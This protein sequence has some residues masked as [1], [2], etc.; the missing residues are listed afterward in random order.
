MPL[1]P[2]RRR[3]ITGSVAG[4][5]APT[6]SRVWGQEIGAPM[7]A[8][9]A[10]MA[11]AP[12]RALPAMAADKAKNH[13]LD[14]FAAMISGAG[15]LPGQAAIKFAR[16]Y[17]GPAVATVVASNIACGP[18]E[19]ALANGVLAHSDE[20]DDSHAPSQSH[21]GAAV[22]PAALAAGERFDIDGER[23]I[24]AVA[25]GYDVGSRVTM[26]MG[27]VTFRNQSHRAT[28]AIAG[29]FGA[30]AAAGAAARLNP[31]QMRWLLDYAAQ[32]SSGIAAWGRDQDHILKAFVFAGMGAR[33]GVTA[34]LLVEAGWTGIDDVFSGESNFF[35]AYA[36][37]ANQ[38]LL[39]EG[40][41]QRFEIA[42]TDIK[43]WTVGSP[44][45]APLDAL[46]ILMKRH[47]FRAAQVRELRVRLAPSVAAVVD[48]RDMPDVSVQH[49]L[50]VMLLD[51]TASFAAAHDRPRMQ[52]ADVLRERAKVSLIA[53]PEL[54]KSLPARPAIVEVVLADGR[55]FSERVDAVRGTA[56]NPMTREEVVDKARDLIAPVLGAPKADVLIRAVL[57]L[58]TRASI[59]SL[60]PLL[61]V[62]AP[63]LSLIC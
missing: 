33:S 27:G 41:G 31:Q 15:L 14:T 17:G 4:I 43:K 5:L 16:A 59:R 19:A 51:G 63:K 7:L 2:I 57:T 39:T 45:Q 48:G 42:R 52:A 25:L 46:D 3:L 23:F 20:T 38:G 37:G 21:P 34:A 35:Q 50:A 22:V 61:Q 32:Q 44:I 8:L 11:A 6:A 9:S 29:G 10:Y 53:D 54:A 56:A 62:S 30:A 26:A 60:R 40:L 24:R 12:D 49:M 36:P 47:G 58:E 18:I 1:D 28:H 55:A 13:I